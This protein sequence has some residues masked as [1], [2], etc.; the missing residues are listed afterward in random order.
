MPG[1]INACRSVLLLAALLAAGCAPKQTST[2][3]RPRGAANTA[4]V[5][6][7]EL[8]LS[9]IRQGWGTPHAR[10]SVEGRPLTIRGRVFERGVGTHA[11]CEWR[12]DLKRSA[13][14]LHAVVGVDDECAGYGSV[15]FVVCADGRELWRSERLSGR[16]APVTVDLDVRG[17]GELALVVEEGGDNNYYDHAD[18]ADAYLELVSGAAALPESRHPPE[19]P[20]PVLVREEPP[21]PQVHA[22]R[23]TGGSPGRPFLFRIPATGREPLRFSATRIP[24]GLELDPQTGIVHGVPTRRG[25]WDMQVQVRNAAGRTYDE[26]TIVI[27]PGAVALTPPMG[28]NS[29]NVWGTSIDEAKVRAA[30]DAMVESGLAAYGYR[31]IIIDDGWAGER[32]E[33]GE[34]TANEKFPD[35]AALARYVHSRGLKFGIYSSPGPLTCACYTGSYRH[36]AQDA[37]TFAR[38]GVDALKYDWCSYGKIARD[39]SSEELQKPYRIMR[40]ALDACGRDVVYMI[41]QYGM[42][43]VWTWGAQVGGNTWRT[44]GDITD[45][46][47]SMS[48]IGFAHDP[49]APYA[50][51]GHWNDPDMLV[52]GML[53]WGPDIRPTRLTPH[54]QLTHITLWSLLA[55]PL[56]LGCDLTQLDDFT[57]TLLTNPEVIEVDQDPAGRAARRIWRR[58]LAEVWA[59]ELFDGSR[60]VG[61]FN[62]SAWPQTIRIRWDEL[63]LTGPQR[64]RD[65]WRRADVGVL[66]DGYEVRV[67]G[68]SAVLLR[69]TAGRG[70]ADE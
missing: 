43:Q 38:W 46:W 67:E 31:Y 18:W 57:L 1:P 25:R 30:A 34:I 52:V 54:E 17:V 16:S 21:E 6:L 35:I 47:E 55:A 28:W 12:I 20:P 32:D 2:A 70:K 42:G 5:W 44:T 24:P 65:L 48:G 9:A 50:G 8:D 36:E 58:G 27:E 68:H 62:R 26:I 15:V 69:L 14:R 23:I 19:A 22:P 39:D 4:R 61:L 60:A 49:M 45:T 64:V 66:E 53:G 59:R 7:D 10:R 3:A 63:G 11:F 51:P 41:C 37:K 13:R 29:W 33:N 56:I 40:A